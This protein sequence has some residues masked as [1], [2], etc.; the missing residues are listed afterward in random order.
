[1]DDARAL[2]A[3]LT[4][5]KFHLLT[6]QREI[7]LALGPRMTGDFELSGILAEAKELGLRHV[8][9]GAGQRLWADFYSELCDVID[10]RDRGELDSVTAWTVNDPRLAGARRG[11]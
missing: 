6:T 1:M 3:L 10:A 7:V 11:E 8:S 5:P 4:D 2:A 9:M